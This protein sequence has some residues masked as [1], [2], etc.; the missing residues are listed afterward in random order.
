MNPKKLSKLND[1]NFLIIFIN[2][3]GIG[4]Y[5]KPSYLKSLLISNLI[6]D[7]LHSLGV[8]LFFLW[9]FTS[10]IGLFS[11]IIS[12]LC[13]AY[14]CSSYVVSFISMCIPFLPKSMLVFTLPFLVDLGLYIPQESWIQWFNSQFIIGFDNICDFIYSFY[15]KSYNIFYNLLLIPYYLVYYPF[16]FVS[17]S[18]YFIINFST[19]LLGVCSILIGV[20]L[21][22]L[23]HV[24]VTEADTIM[25]NFNLIN[26]IPA[27]IMAMFYHGIIRPGQMVVSTGGTFFIEYFKLLMPT[28]DD[29]YDLLKWCVT[30]RAN[31]I[32]NHWTQIGHY[33]ATMSIYPVALFGTIIDPV[34]VFIWFHFTMF[35]HGLLRPSLFLATSLG[36]GIGRFI[37]IFT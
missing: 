19:W 12:M 14:D 7:S 1:L 3:I 6:Y 16:Y 11:F 30:G 33:I 15:N 21:W 4:K 28:W 35:D 32:W 20:K 34:Q 37:G 24:I 2:F 29:C 36:T 17:I 27:Y 22:A 9:D 5:L 25:I 8:F 18:T 13:V 10:M 23:W 26:P 31:L